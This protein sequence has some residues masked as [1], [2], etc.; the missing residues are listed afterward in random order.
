MFALVRE[1]ESVRCTRHSGRRLLELLKLIFAAFWCECGRL[2]TQT[3]ER[4]Y[5]KKAG[6]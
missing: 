6:D 3:S 2:I 5:T 1:K 4:M